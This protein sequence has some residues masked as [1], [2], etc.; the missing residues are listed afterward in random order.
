MPPETD[1]GLMQDFLAET[2][3]LIQQLDA[4]LVK[5]ETAPDGPEA[6]DL[7]SSIYISDLAEMAEAAQPGDAP[8]G[9]GLVSI[10][11]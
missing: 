8:V 5:L 10:L 7:L 11:A 3:E 6:K 2:G 9:T 1:P 4:D